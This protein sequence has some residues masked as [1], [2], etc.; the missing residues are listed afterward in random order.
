MGTDEPSLTALAKGL[1]ITA[2]DILEGKDLETIKEKTRSP[3]SILFPWEM[4]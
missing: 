4:M 1:G 2:V 3:T